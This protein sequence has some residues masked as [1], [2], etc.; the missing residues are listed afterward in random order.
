MDL[1]VLSPANSKT[2]CVFENL[3]EDTTILALKKAYKQ[4]FP[5]LYI[6][7]Q[8]FRSSTRGKALKDTETLKETSE[9]G[10]IY[11]KDLG[12][13]IGWSTVFYIEYAGPLFVYLWFYLNN[14]GELSR[15]QHI[16]AACHSFHYLK[17][18]LETK[19]VHRF[20]HG[21]MPLRNLF[22]NCSYYWSFAAWQAYLINHQSYTAPSYGSAQVNGAL[23]AFILCQIGNFSIHIAL[24]NLRKPGSTERKIPFPTGNP[25]TS[26]FSF[27]SCPNYTYEVGSWLS[28]AVMTQSFSSLIFATLGF[29]QMSQWALGKHR[30]YKKEFSNYPRSRKAIVPF[31]I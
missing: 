17:R 30:N 14:S 9:S 6:S 4:K 3:P 29:M 16:A 20:S 25:F 27:V 31:F 5:D 21:T 1:K 19:F 15:V 7:R 12:P 13:Q 10:V 26:M 23:V 22:K 2:L 18:L 24:K 8:S 11:Y 28:F